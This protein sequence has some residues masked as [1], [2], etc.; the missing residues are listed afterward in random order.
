[1]Y[2]D[3]EPGVT[4][5]HCAEVSAQV[6]P[7]LDVEDIVPGEYSLEVSSPGMERPFF[8]LAQCVDYCGQVVRIA[9]KQSVAGLRKLQGVLQSVRA[10][11]VVVLLE[12]GEVVVP[13]SSIHRMKLW[14]FE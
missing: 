7:L 5:D 2:I 6:S 13:A 11:G 10:E 14:P 9:L 8:S 4:V 12:D 3:A 1:L